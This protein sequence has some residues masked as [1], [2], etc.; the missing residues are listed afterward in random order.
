MT[1][2]LRAVVSVEWFGLWRPSA[3]SLPRSYGL[4]VNQ[5]QL[6]IDGHLPHRVLRSS[7][8]YMNAAG[9]AKVGRTLY[10]RGRDAAVVPLELRAGIVAGQFTPR[11]ARQG[12]WAV[13]HLTLQEAADLSREVGNMSPSKSSLDRLPKQCS[14]HWEAQREA[15]EAQLR[16]ALTVPE[17]AVTVAV[18]LDGVMTP[19]KDGARAP[20]ANRVW[21]RVSTPKDP[22]AVKKWA[23]RG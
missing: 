9:P 6:L 22:R 14:M 20:S 2:S 8:T 17:A 15:F 21:P 1:G 3:R 10:R 13:A 7:E 16:E 5:P 19:M 11:A 23:V 4:D 12:L 18:S